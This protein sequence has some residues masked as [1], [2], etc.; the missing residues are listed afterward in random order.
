MNE[1]ICHDY[2]MIRSTVLPIAEYN[3]GILENDIYKYITSNPFL[4]KYF[5]KALFLSSRNLYDNFTNTPNDKKTYTNLN[6]SLLKYFIRSTT[7]PTPFGF[8]SGVAMGKFENEQ[9]LF[10]NNFFLKICVDHS[11]IVELINKFEKDREILEK[12]TFYINKNC[13]NFGERYYNPYC[14]NIKINDKQTKSS[15][16][17]NIKHLKVVEIIFNA[18]EKGYSY[19]EIIDSVKENYPKTDNII[20][21]NTIQRLIETEYIYTEL[22]IPTYCKDELGY[23]YNI[24]NKKSKQNKQIPLIKN[25]IDMINDYNKFD[26]SNMMENQNNLNEILLGMQVL[27]NKGIAIKADTGMTMA[28]NTLPYYIKNKVE[29]FANALGYLSINNSNYSTLNTLLEQFQEEYGIGVEVKLTELINPNG[30]N[31]L[32]FLNEEMEIKKDAREIEISEIIKDKIIT[33]LYK[34]EEIN[35]KI[36]DFKRVDKY[37]IKYPKSFDLNLFIQRKNNEYKLYIGPNAGSVKA[38]AMFQRFEACFDKQDFNLYNKIYDRIEENCSEEFVEV[39]I[40]E[41]PN[42]S[43]ISNII[44][45]TENYKYTMCLGLTS[46]NNNYEITLDDLY[47]GLDYDMKPYLRSKGLD[48]RVKFVS[49][50]MLYIGATCKLMKLLLLISYQNENNPLTR[51]FDFINEN[52]EYYPEIKIEDVVVSPKR[53]IFKNKD[54][55]SQEDFNSEFRKF[56]NFHDLPEYLYLSANDN[57]LLIYL[58]NEQCIKIL[59]LEY[60]KSKRLLLCNIEEGIL[61][62]KLISSDYGYHIG[63]FVFSVYL[64]KSKDISEN[65]SS[66][67]V[68]NKELVKENRTMTLFR[69]G[70]IYMKIYGLGTRT[71]SFLYTEIVEL[72][73]SLGGIP[74]FFIRYYDK[75]GGA[76]IRLRLK[77]DNEQHAISKMDSIAKWAEINLHKNNVSCIKFDS[78]VREINRYGGLKF[79]AVCEQ[80]FFLDS[81]LVIELLKKHNLKD[82]LICEQIYFTSITFFIKHLFKNEIDAVEAIDSLKLDNN[83][84]SYFKKKDKY[85]DSLLSFV[86]EDDMFQ[87]DNTSAN[88]IQRLCF[89]LNKLRDDYKINDESTTTSK[90]NLIFSII[91][92][93]CNRLTG[94]RNLESKYLELVNCALYHRNVKK[95]KFAK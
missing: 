66:Y 48:K 67:E 33:C 11:W 46:A 25:V 34:K 79:I 27:C 16:E 63:E 43:K 50:N 15:E 21:E 2:F 90:N 83:I 95:K 32:G 76:H 41:E 29:Q 65:L 70:W 60:K 4:T 62:S 64:N 28:G 92:M 88:I 7:R 77:F 8:Y 93:H 91:H 82:D 18:V 9:K 58:N 14:S 81:I 54:I 53:W 45:K 19:L 24:L 89:L 61:N 84:K 17:N 12:L 39:A 22:R 37:E 3:Y 23:I 69:Q 80:I 47:L 52:Y 6:L 10:I 55:K 57:R 1:Y 87:F 71:N 49:D 20:I 73:N 44:N 68:I 94:N 30:F 36:E 59:Y 42:I 85:F 72:I 35:F 13:Y 78:Y 75:E 31:A 5:N 51:V 56:V 26:K 40:I 38:G 74:Y 86:F